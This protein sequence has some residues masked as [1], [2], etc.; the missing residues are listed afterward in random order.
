MPKIEFTKKDANTLLA[1]SEI[2]KESLLANKAF[3][4][5]EIE[6]INE[7]LAILKES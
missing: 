4:L 7:K 2:T 5:E 6:K 3:L 1:T